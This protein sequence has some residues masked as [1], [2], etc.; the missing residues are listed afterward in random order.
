MY[1]KAQSN[2]HIMPEGS[3]GILHL[4]VVINV[5]M[6]VSMTWLLLHVVS[7]Q[8][9]TLCKGARVEWDRGG[10]EMGMAGQNGEGMDGEEGG[11]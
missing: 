7:D 11:L 9:H 6:P 2:G 4:T 10:Q 3:T 8:V 5:T 1:L